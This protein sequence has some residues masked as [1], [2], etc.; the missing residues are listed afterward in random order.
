MAKKILVKVSPTGDV[1]ITTSGYQ[2][3]ECQTATKD[4]EKALGAK[5]SDTPTAEASLQ[6]ARHNAEAR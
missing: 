2:G 3:S 6:Q 1:Q 4:L 5:T